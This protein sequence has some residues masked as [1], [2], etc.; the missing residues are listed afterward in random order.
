MDELGK[1]L[2]HTRDEVVA[3]RRRADD[4]EREAKGLRQEADEL[5]RL[6]DLARSS[7]R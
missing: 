5:E 6:A 2:I 3:K 1:L 4:L 7:S